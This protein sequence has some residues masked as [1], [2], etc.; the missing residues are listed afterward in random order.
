MGKG[1]YWIEPVD[2]T[3]NDFVLYRTTIIDDPSEDKDGLAVFRTREHFPVGAVFHVLHHTTDFVIV[4]KD[5]TWGNRYHVRPFDGEMTWDRFNELRKGS[6]LYRAGFVHG[7]GSK[8][9]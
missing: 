4:S 2:R 1:Y 5:R 8:F 7:D 6:I 9:F 3:L